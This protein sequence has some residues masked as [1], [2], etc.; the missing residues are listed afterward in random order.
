MLVSVGMLVAA[1]CD[2]HRGAAQAEIDKGVAA[3]KAGDFDLA[4]SCFTAAIGHD[5]SSAEALSRRAWIQ[6]GNKHYDEAISDASEAIRIDSKCWRAYAAR[7]RAYEFSESHTDPSSDYD[8]AVE[9]SPPD[10]Y[11]ALA[12]RGRYHLWQKQWKEALR[13]FNAAV[14]RGDDR[15]YVFKLRGEAFAGSGEPEKG[16]ADFT[17][18]CATGH[19]GDKLLCRLSHYGRGQCLMKLHRDKEAEDAFDLAGMTDPAFKR[20]RPA[21]SMLP[22]PAITP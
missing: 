11:R 2:L 18:A 12:E 16:L 22:D 14:A 9:L 1:G 6:S 19:D 13:D 20:T 4:P 17:R 10:E 15:V 8:A 7:G 5:R 3:S 21:P